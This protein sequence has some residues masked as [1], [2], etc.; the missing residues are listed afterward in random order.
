MKADAVGQIEQSVALHSRKLDAP[1]CACHLI[2]WC[3]GSGRVSSAEQ[4]ALARRHLCCGG[5]DH[6][7]VGHPRRR[8]SRSAQ[9]RPSPLRGNHSVGRAAP[10]PGLL[11]GY[12]SATIIYGRAIQPIAWVWPLTTVLFAMQAYYALG[13]GLVTPLFGVPAAVYNT[14]VAVVACTRY[15]ISHGI[16]PRLWSRAFSR[17]GERARTFSARPRCGALRTFSSPC[18]HHRFLRDGG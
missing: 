13:R 1:V 3:L 2:A 12:A 9:A 5:G 8:A 10:P 4:R 14:V 17:S 7:D 6:R 16:V 11:V 18:F 15:A